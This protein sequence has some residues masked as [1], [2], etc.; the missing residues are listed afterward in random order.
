MGNK[1]E[2]NSEVLELL[3]WVDGDAT[4]EGNKHQM[5]KSF[6][7]KDSETTLEHPWAIP[8]VQP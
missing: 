8:G 3:T 2:N 6:W 1:V 5:R 7:Q 4:N